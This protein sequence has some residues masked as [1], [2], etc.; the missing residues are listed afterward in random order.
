[1]T[2]TDW[3]ALADF[4]D[5][6]FS[7]LRAAADGLRQYAAITAAIGDPDELNRLAKIMRGIGATLWAEHIGRIA[8][9]ASLTPTLTPTRCPTCGSDNPRWTVGDTPHRRMLL[10]AFHCPDAWHNG[11][12]AT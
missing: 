5:K 11:G 8:V 3:L 9:A 6:A 12:G 7:D 2:D 10:S 4:L 1:M